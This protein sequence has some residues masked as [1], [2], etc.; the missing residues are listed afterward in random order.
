MNTV[1]SYIVQKH[2]SQM[3]EDVATEALAFILRSS[4]AA[5]HGVVKLLRAIEPSLPALYFRTQQTEGDLRPDRWG[6]DEA[7]TPHVFVENKFWAGLT[8]NQPVSY[9]RHLAGHPD[10]SVLLVV[11]PEARQVTVWSELERRLAQA[12]ISTLP[13]ESPAGVFRVAGTGIGPTMALTSWRQ[14]LSQIEAELA[15]EPRRRHDLQQL[16][17]LC[18]ATDKNAFVPISPAELT[19]QRAPALLLQLGSAMKDAVAL[20]IDQGV[21][22]TDGLMPSSSWERFGRYLSFPTARGVGAWFGVHFRLWRDHGRTPL[23]LVFYST[24]WGRAPEV[25][26][27]VEPWARRESIITA[28]VD[29]QFVVGINLATGEEKDGFVQSIV[30]RLHEIST[31]LKALPEKDS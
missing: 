7:N 24:D 19:N 22:S 30:C 28:M 27:L 16:R 25:R 5:R 14:L 2:L 3:N 11:A 18:D 1:F 21:L 20:G 4:D 15:D 13:R 6:L 17:A 12:A 23:W 26:A 9:L 29:D 10:P 31:Q 8:E